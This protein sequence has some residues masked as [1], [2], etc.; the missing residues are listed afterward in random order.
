MMCPF[1]K[2]ESHYVISHYQ[3]VDTGR[4][5]FRRVRRC[6]DCGA[7]FATRETYSQNTLK[8]VEEYKNELL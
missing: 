4:D 6:A 2:S 7:T 1:C 8:E 5:E 3:T